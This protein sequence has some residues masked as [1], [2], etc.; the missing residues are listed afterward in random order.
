MNEDYEWEG[1]SQSQL[2][3]IYLIVLLT[4]LNLA[5]AALVDIAKE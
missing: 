5:G 4:L 1:A 3:I 2:T